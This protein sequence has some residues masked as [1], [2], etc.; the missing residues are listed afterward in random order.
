MLAAIAHGWDVGEAARFLAHPTAEPRGAGV[1]HIVQT[2]LCPAGD[3][4]ESVRRYVVAAAIC[5]ALAAAGCSS[6]TEGTPTTTAD[7]AADLWDPC[8]L[9]QATV[10]A[11]GVDPATKQN[12]I[13]GVEQSGWKI[14]TWRGGSYGITVYSTAKDIAYYKAKPENTDFAPVT[15]AGRSGQQFR[16]NGTTRDL[17]C[18]MLFPASQG[19]FQITLLGWPDNDT[20]ISDACGKLTDVAGQLVPKLPQ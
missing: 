12:G 4:G 7:K 15:V 20:P 1:R 2:D 8:S 17:K 5:T 14:C 18:D 10:Q 19:I 3:V 11:M 9:D 13:G 6:A 16:V